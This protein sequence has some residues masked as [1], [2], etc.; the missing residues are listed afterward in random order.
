MPPIPKTFIALA[1][2]AC[3]VTSMT[4]AGAAT[5]VTPP[6]PGP[7]WDTTIVGYDWASRE[8]HTHVPILVNAPL[9]TQSLDA[10]PGPFMDVELAGLAPLRMYKFAGSEGDILR[11]EA[12]PLGTAVFWSMYVKPGVWTLIDETTTQEVAAIEFTETPSLGTTRGGGVLYR[13]YACWPPP[14]PRP[15]ETLGQTAPT[16][17][18]AAFSFTPYG[19][20]AVTTCYDHSVRVDA[21]VSGGSAA[22]S[23]VGGDYHFSSGACDSV[24]STTKPVIV[25]QNVRYTKDKYSDGSWKI[26]ATGTT[27][28]GSSLTEDVHFSAPAGT[29]RWHTNVNF[30]R[31]VSEKN[32]GTV[33]FSWG[34]AAFEQNMGVAFAASG[35]YNTKLAVSLV[36]PDTLRT[37]AYDFVFI[38]GDQYATGLVGAVWYRGV[39]S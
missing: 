24:S 31:E 28:G 26:Y 7:T 27:T 23:N 15:Y 1:T 11:S 13:C 30:K 4:S 21:K 5:E 25:R 8:N 22:Q 9:I 36:P 18:Q 17:T 39:V 6:V 2:F 35:G 20:V 38:A 37:H 10:I 14:P 16:I 3:F 12:N 33:H 34:A 29:T 32:A 19:T